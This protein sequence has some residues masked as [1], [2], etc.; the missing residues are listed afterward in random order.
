MTEMKARLVDKDGNP[1]GTAANPLKI[2]GDVGGGVPDGGTTGQ[3]LQKKTDA[4]QDTEW[5]D[6]SVATTSWGSI[7]GTLADQ[8]DLNM[9]LG[10]KVP[11]TRT[12]NSK[13]L[14]TDISLTPAD[15]GAQ[16]ADA[17][18]TA[19]AGVT[20]DA[21]KL[22]YF[23]GEDQ[24]G[25]TDITAFA[26][27]LLGS[28]TEAA[29]QAV[30]KAASS[31]TATQAIYVDKAATGTGDGTSWTNAFTTIQAA[32]DSLP[33]IINHAVVIIIR[34]GS[35]PYNENITIQRVVAAG[36]ITIR[37]E[38]YWYGTVAA[39]KTGKITLGVS[40]YGYA[41]RA[42]I[43]AGDVIWA[44]KWSGAVGASA[45]S[46]SI[47]DTVSSVSGAEV[48]LTTNAGKT[49]DTTW[50]YRIVKTQL[51]SNSN[52]TIELQ[53]I[54]G[55]TVI[56]LNISGQ[57]RPVF[58]SNTKNV[59]VQ[60]SYLSSVASHVV[61]LAGQ[62]GVMI[63]NCCISGSSDWCRGVY[64]L[65]SCYIS[66]VGSIFNLSGTGA[67]GLT[68]GQGSVGLINNCHIRSSVATGILSETGSIAIRSNILNEATTPLNPASNPGTDGSYII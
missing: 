60:Y 12:V 35:T 54:T 1:L 47:I 40:D 62:S 19:L 38:Y 26:R 8:T 43:A 23:T 6:V 18:L 32:V 22:P 67:S 46:E 36:S 7:T 68:Y 49:I 39:S 53:N 28:T 57:T 2:S 30:L 52:R 45:P 51:S 17:T 59:Y 42:Q 31:T 11:T 9:A 33:A 48:S 13:A 14:S 25:V 66:A 44:T 63:S 15:V 58:T 16:P 21:N 64:A 41:D 3:V 37:G 61:E 29:A 50:N 56:G 55:V 34:K 10:G 27:S 4:D 24:A 20:S 5:G 65:E